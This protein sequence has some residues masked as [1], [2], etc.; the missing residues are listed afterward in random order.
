[1]KLNYFA[2]LIFLKWINIGRLDP[3]S[4]QKKIKINKMVNLVSKI[5]ENKSN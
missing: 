1:M 3:P 4:S 2:Y 5:F